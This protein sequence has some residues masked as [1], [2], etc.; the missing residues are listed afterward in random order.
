MSLF[1]NKRA[2]KDLHFRDL[3]H[4]QRVAA[5]KLIGE[6]PIGV[7]VIASN[8][9]T[10]IDSPKKEIFKEKQHLYNYLVRFLMERLTDA[11]AKKVNIAGNGPARLFVTFSR[12]SGTDYGVMQEYF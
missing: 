10:I 1:P 6:K 9:G 5:T 8:K 11:C 7:C 2:R 3:N 4:S 12:R